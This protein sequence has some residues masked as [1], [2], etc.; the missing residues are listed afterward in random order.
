MS[1][2]IIKT[3]KSVF[4]TEIEALNK[5]RDSLDDVFGQIINLILQCK[6]K[7]VITGIGKPGHI[8]CKMAA[9]FASLGTP[10]F[11]L[12]PSEALHGDLG[13]LEADDLVMLISYSG[14]S[15][16]VTALLPVLK[17]I[18]CTTISITGNKKSTLGRACDYG[19]VFPHFEEA[20]YLHLAPTSSTTALLALGDAMAVVM[21]KLRNYTREDFGLHHPAGALGRKLL[22]RVS[23]LMRQGHDNAV[24]RRGCSLKNAIVEMSTKG[25]CMITIVDDNNVACGVLTDG[26]LRR[27]LEAGVDVYS[28]SIDEA[29]TP[30]PKTIHGN[31]MAVDALQQMKDNSISCMPVVNEQN[32]AIGAI[33]MADI[34]KAG[35]VK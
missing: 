6:G 32:G 21:S 2:D 34:L 27:K 4:D 19:Y 35:I 5:T 12:H 8:A 7:L 18:G 15:H 16:E 20:C 14:E 10:S 31:E 13:M 17:E 29:M 25:L 1:Y 33:L 23:D 9:T 28:M 26:D 22:V 3:A 11:Y 30:T 24:V